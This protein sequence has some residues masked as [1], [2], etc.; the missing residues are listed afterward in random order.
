MV[1]SGSE[2]INKQRAVGKGNRDSVSA[3]DLSSV[4]VGRSAAAPNKRT[5]E[6]NGA[7]ELVGL[8]YCA[9]T[10]YRLNDIHVILLYKLIYGFR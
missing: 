3:A 1:R 9:R 5:V 10:L 6:M 8:F 7:R 2:E 4:M